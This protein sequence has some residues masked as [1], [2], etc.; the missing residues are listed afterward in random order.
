M[1]KYID[2]VLV[3]LLAGIIFGSIYLYY[4]GA[5]VAPVHN[6]LVMPPI[7]FAPKPLRVQWNLPAPEVLPAELTLNSKE[8]KNTKFG[9]SLQL[10]EQSI[11]YNGNCTQSGTLA[12]VHSGPVPIAIIESGSTIL[13][14]NEYEYETDGTNCIKINTVLTSAIA[15]W[16]ITNFTA[17]NEQDMHDWVAANIGDGCIVDPV[18]NWPQEPSMEQFV[19]ERDYEVCPYMNAY[20]LVRNP[21]TNRA[22]FISYGQEPSFWRDAD[23]TIFYDSEVVSSLHFY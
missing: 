19:F 3:L 10:P 15:G 9:F 14:A 7:K 13:I 17:K 5:F 21:K 11:A 12:T 16:R 1:R 23:S 2:T 8:Y 20:T 22:F 4:S 18:V 6:D